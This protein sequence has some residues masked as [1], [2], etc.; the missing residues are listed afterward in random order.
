MAV[1]L[2]F[3]VPWTNV[4]INTVNVYEYQGTATGT[5]PCGR[6]GY[7]KVY[8]HPIT[9]NDTYVVY[10][11]GSIDNLYRLSFT[12]IDGIEGGLSSPVYGFADPSQPILKRISGRVGQIVGLDATFYRNGVPQDPYAVRNVRIYR[13]SVEPGNLMAEII[14][15]DPDDTAYPTPA[16]RDPGKP[17]YYKTLFDIPED[18]PVPDI[19]FDVWNFIADPPSGTDGTYVDLDDESLWSSHCNRFWIYPDGW[20]L[21]D[22]L[23][24]PRIGFEPIDVKFR[25]GEYRYLEVGMMPLPLYDYDYNRIVPMMPYLQPMITIRTRNFEMIVENEPAE[26]GLRQG[27][28]RSNPFVVRYNLDTSRFLMG[29]YVYNISIRLPNGQMIVSPEF[30]FTISRGV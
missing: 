5:D 28:Y 13:R 17:G 6:D 16:M 7:V 2:S 9:K 11:D 8:E 26:I 24:N 15:P 12:N 10:P 20:Y 29:T 18:F 22:G 25:S 3:T 30:T 23:L 1:T 4:P 14:F 27:S 19:Y 21:D